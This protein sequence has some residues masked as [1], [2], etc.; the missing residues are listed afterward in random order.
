MDIQPRLVN[1]EELFHRRLFRIPQYQRAYSWQKKHRQALFDDVLH[2]HAEGNGRTHFMATIVGLRRET[3]KI[4]TDEYQVVEIVDGQQRITTLVILY[5]AIAKALDRSDAIERDVGEQIDKT[6]VKP[7]EVCPVLLQTNHDTSDCFLN[8]LS[9]GEHE[10]L[11][12][13]KSAAERELLM[14]ISESENFVESWIRKGYT[15]A[16][17]VS[18]IK[19]KLTFI[20]HEIG[21]EALVYTVFEVLNSRGL[22]VSWFD[23]LKSML[24]AVVFESGTGNEKETLDQIHNLWSDIYRIIGHRLGLSTEALRF[25][26]TLKSQHRP[27]RVLGEENAANQLLDLTEGRCPGVM[28]ITKW[29]KSVTEVVD[30]LVAKPQ[31]NAVTKIGHARLVAV[32]VYLRSDLND[33]ERT[34]I[35]DRWENISFRIFGMFGKDARTKVG[36]FVRLAWSISNGSLSGNDIMERLS[37]IGQD[38]PI[39]KAVKEL[40]ETN[41]YEGWGDELRYFL[42]QYEEY[43]AKEAGQNF[44]NEQWDR[45][46]ESS[47][48][49]SIEHIMPQSSD[50]WYVHCLGNLILLPPRLNASLGALSPTE[51]H[52][53]YTRT[54]LLMAQAVAST[55]ERGSRWKKSEVFQREKTLL[56]WAAG[57]WAD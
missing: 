6:L 33:E 50:K 24:M 53:K 34:K 22:E 37:E 21:D 49:E 51:K 35:L 38:Y 46:W 41:C 42:Y 36:D 12:T 27:N 16:D 31:L 20:L 23:R 18:Y 48:S 44:D 43:L 5:K 54:G 55:L 11:S 10:Q 45:I 47:A 52:E 28:E 17:L 14:A 9:T 15:L 8:Y 30:E 13:A 7:D 29:I 56:E 26:A 39:S 1:L 57:R 3:R 2:S 40:E 4:V 32:A 25:A 19:N